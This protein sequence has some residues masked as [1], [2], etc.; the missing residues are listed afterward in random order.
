MYRFGI[1]LGL[2]VG[3]MWAGRGVAQ[4]VPPS[5]TKEIR[6]LLD[7]YCVEC[8]RIGNLKGGANLESL[9]GI[10]KGGR[11]GKVLLVAGKPDESRIVT[12]TEGKTRPF[13]PPKNAKK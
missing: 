10:M 7:K 1:A 4:E 3:L 8:H 11:K 9:E 2:G 12:T 5:Y 13:M 6:P